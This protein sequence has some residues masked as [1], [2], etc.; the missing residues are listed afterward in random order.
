MYSRYWRNR[1]PPAGRD[2]ICIFNKPVSSNVFLSLL[3]LLFFLFSAAT[4]STFYILAEALLFY[5][6]I[7]IRLCYR[8]KL[9]ILILISWVW[10]YTEQLFEQWA[11]RGQPVETG[12][13]TDLKYPDV[14]KYPK[15]LPILN[16]KVPKQ[17]CSKKLPCVS[18]AWESYVYLWMILHFF[19][20][21]RLNTN[22]MSTFIYL[23]LFQKYYIVL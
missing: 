16:G 8:L 4:M 5:S 7:I 20:V 6:I 14:L 23:F 9:K 13:T 12:P 18:S 19:F 22:K 2:W 10:G 1:A 3:T 15:L 11:I 21:W 17:H